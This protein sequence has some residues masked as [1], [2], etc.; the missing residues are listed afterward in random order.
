MCENKS[1]YCATIGT[2]NS[3]IDLQLINETQLYR[4]HGDLKTEA[5]ILELTKKDL[6]QLSQHVIGYLVA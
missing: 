2:F 6:T 5:T 4:T 3:L 1:L